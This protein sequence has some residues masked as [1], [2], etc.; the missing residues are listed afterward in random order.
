M[1]V[2]YFVKIFLR[3]NHVGKASTRAWYADQNKP[4]NVFDNYGIK[5]KTINFIGARLTNGLVREGVNKLDNVILGNIGLSGKYLGRH[6]S[7]LC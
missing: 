3:N 2:H 7:D 5:F 6:Q 1:E 4:N